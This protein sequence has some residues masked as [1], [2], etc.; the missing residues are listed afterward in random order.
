MSRRFGA[1][2]NTGVDSEN[3]GQVVRTLKEG[4]W[5]RT[6]VVQMADGSL[7]VRKS[8]K[9]DAPPGPW[10]VS[11]L[12][13]EIAY[14]SN[15]PRTAR[16]SFPPLLA[17][18]DEAGAPPSVGYEVPFY[19]DHVDAG[20]LARHSRLTQA[21]VDEFQDALA[22]VLLDEVHVPLSA[23]SPPLSE[24]VRDVVEHALSALEADPTLAGL[25]RAETVQLNQ[26]Q[27]AGPR[28]AFAQIVAEGRTLA[29][30][31]AEP[32]VRLHGDCFLENILWLRHELL[33]ASGVPR[34][35]LIDP[36]SVAGVMRGPPLFDFVKYISYATGELPALRSE[37]VDVA[38][39][40][41]GQ[42]GYSYRVRLEAAQVA[43]FQT[44]DWHT[45]L[46]RAF[47]TK[48]GPAQGGLYCLIDGYFSVAMAVNTSGVQ[49]QA[50]L[51]KA[52]QD[53]NAAL[54][55]SRCSEQRNV[56]LE[57]DLGA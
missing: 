49:R 40:D 39:F 7:R 56:A 2:V 12:R 6:E 28:A 30:L 52:T 53:F 45:R 11:A 54:G 41:D 48:Y 18:W 4:Y 16:C 51:L 27:V 15:L 31:D 32:Q 25:I 20:E 1:G 21:E 10:G 9:G 36:V 23:S 14:L 19:A 26:R 3:S 47:E 38:G 34:L 55:H 57:P 46:R 43:P 29:A 44:R 8:S 5:D 13:R 50:R 42:D 17:E 33:A 35:L 37:C 24:H 22:T